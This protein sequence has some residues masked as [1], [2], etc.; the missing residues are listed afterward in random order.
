MR[1]DGRWD[2]YFDDEGCFP[3]LEPAAVAALE[4][5]DSQLLANEIEKAEQA[6]LADA[7]AGGETVNPPSGLVHK[8]FTQMSHPP[9]SLHLRVPLP[10]SAEIF[11]SISLSQN[12][13]AQ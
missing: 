5:L 1:E 7:I 4:D 8:P 2:T 6:A 9:Y 13:L 12:S 11:P 3:S 10:G